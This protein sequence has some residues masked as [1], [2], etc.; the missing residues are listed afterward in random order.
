LLNRTVTLSFILDSGATDVLIPP[1]IAKQLIE[2]S[3]ITEAD[4]IG[5]AIYELADGSK[6]KST[7]F[8]L[9]ELVVGSQ[10]VRNV[11]ANIGPDRSSLLLGQSFLANF[12]SWTLDNERH[13][14]VLSP[15]SRKPG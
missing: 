7:R 1:K 10:V 13:I 15:K 5:D 12:S 9:R 4:F 11:A 6:L 8:Y 14:L 2:T 3:T